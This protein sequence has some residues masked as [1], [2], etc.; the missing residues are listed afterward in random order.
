MDCEPHINTQEREIQTEP[1]PRES[2]DK[3]QMSDKEK[4]ISSLKKQLAGKDEEIRSLMSD[5]TQLYQEYLEITQ[6]TI[7]FS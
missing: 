4:E 5:M 1:D 6:V 7:E 3:Q 2:R